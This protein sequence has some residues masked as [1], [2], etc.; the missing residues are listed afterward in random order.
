M[1]DC[2]EDRSVYNA[3]SEVEVL[4][5]RPVAQVWKQF[6]NMGSWVTSHVIEEI[7]G[8]R[9]TVGS[10]T[11]VS[12]KGANQEGYPAPHHHYCKIIKVVPE[13][14]YVLKTYSEKGGSYGVHITAFDDAHFVAKDGGT[15]LTFSFF[16]EFRGER[17]AKDPAAINMDASREGMVKNLNTLK[18]IVE[19]R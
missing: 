9:G 3:H 6:L 16:G 7:Y 5:D 4:I 17:V 8:A 11:R 14:Q 15:I 1:S 10:I 13:R 19:G 2:D 12:F 18:R